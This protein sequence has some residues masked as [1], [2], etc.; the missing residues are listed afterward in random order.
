[1]TACW[2]AQA[3][4]AREAAEARI[5]K[6]RELAEEKAAQREEERLRELEARAQ[7]EAAAAA[8]QARIRGSAARKVCELRLEMV[9]LPT[10]PPTDDGCTWW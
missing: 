2:L 6:E 7:E 8:I 9:P 5:A 1:M 3:I 4:E 10:P